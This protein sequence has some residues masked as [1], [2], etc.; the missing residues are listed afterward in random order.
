MTTIELPFPLGHGSVTMTTGR[1][2]DVRIR[3]IAPADA[4]LLVDLFHQ[5]SAETRRLRFFVPR[6]DVPTEVIWREAER[7]A[8]INPQ[9]EVALIA[10]VSEAE[11]ECAVGVAR[12]VRDAGDPATAEVAI[13]VR[14]DYQG[15]GLGAVLFD[16][17]VQVALVRGLGRLRA[18][19][20]AE[21]MGMRRLIRKTGLPFSSETRYGE[22]TT[23]IELSDA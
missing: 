15:E 12:M 20:L 2:R 8:N 3:H 23:T 18:V 1:G 13:V 4:A 19:S 10:T 14:D 9:V 6:S 5:L 17:L 11:Q 16:L 21:N 22:T 7:D